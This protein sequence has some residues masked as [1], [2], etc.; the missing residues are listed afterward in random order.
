MTGKKRI[1]PI[2][3]CINFLFMR[4]PE[5]FDD[6]SSGFCFSPV[7]SIATRFTN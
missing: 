2:A 7:S 3:I 6:L 4:T 1:F 5:E